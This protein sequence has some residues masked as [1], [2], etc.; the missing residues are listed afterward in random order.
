MD[1]GPCRPHIADTRTF[2]V[3][4]IKESK[5]ERYFKQ[6]KKELRSKFGRNSKSDRNWWSYKDFGNENQGLSWLAKTE[7]AGNFEEFVVFPVESVFN[8]PSGLRRRLLHFI[9]SETGSLEAAKVSGL[10]T[11][12][13]W[14]SAAAQDKKVITRCRLH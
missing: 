11:R 10:R 6:H 2:E 13:D 5:L 3:Q 14:A 9:L 8:C 12:Q 4:G 7:A 1:R